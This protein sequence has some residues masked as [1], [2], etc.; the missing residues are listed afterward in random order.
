MQLPIWL[1]CALYVFLNSLNSPCI[2]AQQNTE[3]ADWLYSQ[4]DYYRAISEYK[5]VYYHS[6][7][8]NEKRDCVY[9]ISRSYLKS[10]KY[11]SSI[12]YATSLLND[13]T[14]LTSDITNANMCIGLSY[15]GMNTRY[16][17]GTFFQQAMKNDTSGFSLFYLALLDAENTDY[18]GAGEKYTRLLSNYPG[19]R[20]ADLAQE[21]VKDVSFGKDIPRK[22]NLLAATM[23]TFIPGLGQ[24][25]SG[26]YYDAIQAF[27]YVAAFAFTTYASYH[28]DEK[29]NSNYLN[30]YI[31]VSL[32]ALFHGGN[33]IGAYHTADYH[34]VKNHERFMNTIREKTFRIEY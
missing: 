9:N 10:K 33:I 18:D 20:V 22:S 11:K 32:L 23:S 3:Y 8:S 1:T 34:N 6:D 26:H 31:S 30:T 7:N 28:Y 2:L 5:K 21:L 29:F 14:S 12:L 15:Y 4:R 25:Y 27:A 16:M 24:A 19:A 17:A 13:S